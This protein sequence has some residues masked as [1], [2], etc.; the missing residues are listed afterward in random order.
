VP[1]EQSTQEQD[2][3][4]RKSSMTLVKSL[5]FTF[6]STGLVVTCL[7][8]GAIA[9]N[10]V[11]PA[12]KVEGKRFIST[13]GGFS[14]AISETPSQTIDFGT[15]AAKKKGVDVGKLYIWKFE[16]FTY[17]IMYSTS[18]NSDGNPVAQT[19][20]EVIAGSRSGLLNSGAKLVSEKP[21]SFLNKHPGIEF[22]YLSEGAKFV[23]RS[24]LVGSVGY[25]VVGAFAD[26][27]D[28]KEMLATLDSFRLLSNEE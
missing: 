8:A 1:T 15:E 5:L 3:N 19:L 28:E 13:E 18:F 20:K 25:Q 24:F 27:K 26:V 12:T 16:K 22:H 10:A 4:Q 14:V 7:S 23:N 11:Q 21:L 6:L 9:Q 2:I 17:T